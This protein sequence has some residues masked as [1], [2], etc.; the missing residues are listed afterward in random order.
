MHENIRTP[1][2]GTITL[3]PHVS[4]SLELEP[5][6]L[7]LDI[8]YAIRLCSMHIELSGGM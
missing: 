3:G 4:L 2:V 7:F 1:F 5:P 6:L 8:A